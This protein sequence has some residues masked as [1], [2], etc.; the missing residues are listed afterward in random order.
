V[1]GMWP[2]PI[3]R[4]VGFLWSSWEGAKP[5][6]D[7]FAMAFDATNRTTI[8]GRVVKRIAKIAPESTVGAFLLKTDE[9]LPAGIE[10]TVAPFKIPGTYKTGDY[11][12][13]QAP[14]APRVT[15][16]AI[17]HYD[18]SSGCGAETETCGSSEYN[19]LSFDIAELVADDHAP[20]NGVTYAVYLERTAEEART[21]ST[22]LVLFGRSN[23]APLTFGTYVDASWEGED[24]FITVSALDAA[25]N[26]SPRS[27]PFQ[28]SRSEGGCA[29][30]LQ[31]AHRPTIATLF[32]ALAVL[33]WAR[34]RRRR[35]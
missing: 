29:I 34:R 10:L 15:S 2:S 24:A 32:A 21:A 14:A 12:D 9:P 23:G 1:A 25:A 18:L 33:G 27:E 7:S 16:G 3:P 30:R 6:A 5:P 17:T 19:Y 8:Q 20:A 28:V 35:R 26:E 11:V 4:N 13:D 22:A 31:R